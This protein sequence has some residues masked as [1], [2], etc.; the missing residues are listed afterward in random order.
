MHCAY[1]EA[2]FSATRLNQKNM[3]GQIKE[4][5]IENRLLFRKSLLDVCEDYIGT[6][7][8]EAYL[9]MASKVRQ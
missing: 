8:T 3:L 4:R 1:I 2:I 9:S 7:R 6:E 5:E